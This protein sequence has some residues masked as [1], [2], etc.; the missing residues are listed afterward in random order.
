MIPALASFSV[1]IGVIFGAF[2]AH[3]LKEKL[4]AYSLGIWDTASFYLLIMMSGVLTLSLYGRTRP[5]SKPGILL[6]VVGTYVFSGS[7]YALAF[8]GKRWLGAITPLGGMS[9]ILGWLLVS[10]SLFKEP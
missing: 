8:S 2:G 3:A 1:M 4:D 7:L 5:V 9:V 10:V 6:I